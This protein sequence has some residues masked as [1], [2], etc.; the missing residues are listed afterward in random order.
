M[1]GIRLRHSVIS[2]R[3]NRLHFWVP[4]PPALF[5]FAQQ[6]LSVDC[7]ELLILLNH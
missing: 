7:M 4:P 3:I 2:L 5:F 6:S 1:Q